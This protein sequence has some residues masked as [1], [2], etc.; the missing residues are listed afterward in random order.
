MKRTFSGR[1][2]AA[3]ADNRLPS[4]YAGTNPGDDFCEFNILFTTTRGTS[5]EATAR[6]LYPNRWAAMLQYLSR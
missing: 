1:R 5:C 2:T 6:Q 3:A 4:E